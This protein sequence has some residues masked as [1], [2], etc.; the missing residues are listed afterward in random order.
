MNLLRSAVQPFSPIAPC[1][2]VYIVRRFD[3]IG[4]SGCGD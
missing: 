1:F 2:V 4:F 3:V